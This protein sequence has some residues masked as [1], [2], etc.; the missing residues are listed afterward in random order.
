M[1]NAFT[2]LARWGGQGAPPDRPLFACREYVAGSECCRCGR[3]LLR[4]PYCPDPVPDICAES[5]APIDVVVQ[6]W[7]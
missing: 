4:P 7:R 3:T 5:G 1:T 6:D 2:P